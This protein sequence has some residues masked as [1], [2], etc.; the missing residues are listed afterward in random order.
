MSFLYHKIAM[1][2]LPVLLILILFPWIPTYG[3]NQPNPSKL[4]SKKGREVDPNK[5]EVRR[6][7]ESGERYLREEAYDQ[8]VEEFKKASQLS[9][10]FPVPHLYLGDIFLIKGLFEEAIAEYEKAK[11][12][13][14]PHPL[15]YLKLAKNYARKGQY[16][17]AISEFQTLTRLHPEEAGF[18]YDLAQLYTKAGFTKEAQM[19]LQRANELAESRKG[20]KLP[21]K[22]KEENR[23]S[24]IT[25]ALRLGDDFLKNRMYD[26][27]IEQFRMAVELDPKA[28]ITH[29]K[30]GDAYARKGMFDKAKE[31]YEEVRKLNPN[32]PL[33]YLGLGVVYSRQFE[34]GEAVKYF[35]KGL[36]LDPRFSPLHFELAMAY[37]KDDQLGKAIAELEKTVELD[38][39]NS[40]PAEV[41]NQVKKE[42]EAE[43][44]FSII[45]NEQFLLKF[46][47]Q[48]E[49]SFVEGVLLS[50]EK[51][52]KKLVTDLN[53]RPRQ[54]IIVKLYADLKEFQYA[55][56]TPPW[57]PGGVA[58]TTGQKILLATPKRE[59]N[60]EKLPSVITHE[61]THAFTNLMT[62]GN[63]PGWIHEGLALYEASQWEERRENSLKAA[64]REGK[65]F[66]LEE[67]EESFLRL[68]DPRLIDLAYAAS[69]TAVDYLI[70]KYGREKLKGLLLQFSKG[71]NF[72]EA[73]QTVLGIGEEEFQKG[74]IEFIQQKYR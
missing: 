34:I 21:E 62:Y 44:G 36:S 11:K 6:H 2:F 4:N 39:K 52:Y 63:H 23:R 19:E 25:K 51:A 5:E 68:K 9:P 30:L 32:S 37:L 22:R 48:L 41:L 71:K 7:M 3:Q 61:L 24:L 73:S 35:H 45:Q 16:D 27:A 70:E 10:Q 20:G 64:I 17:K 47:P 31:Q 72:H 43:E 33:S 49:R 60:V 66:R 50:L 59:V 1:L 67:L 40:I 55:A 14:P 26:Q 58:S 54:K 46:S 8:A 69:Y 13:N 29:Q 12:L 53:S 28:I 18:H 56:S 74:W 57:F 15:P 42:K 38:P 65:L